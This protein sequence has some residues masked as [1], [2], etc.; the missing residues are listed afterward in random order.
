MGVFRKIIAFF[1]LFAL[2]ISLC[3]FVPLKAKAETQEVSV[4][5]TTGDADALSFVC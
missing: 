2:V 5:T 1:A 3:N 4:A